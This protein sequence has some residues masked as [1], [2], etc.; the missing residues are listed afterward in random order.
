MRE[1]NYR[2][3]Y[4]A[5]AGHTGYSTSG[6]KSSYANSKRNGSLQ[7]QEVNTAIRGSDRFVSFV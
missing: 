3:A 1:T 5:Q 6:D 7:E 2:S 4:F